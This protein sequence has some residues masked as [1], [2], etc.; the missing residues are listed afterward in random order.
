MITD[1]GGPGAGT[2]RSREP[3]W[4]SPRDT[5]ATE[6]DG[7]AVCGIR[8]RNSAF[9]KIAVEPLPVGPLFHRG[10]RVV[11]SRYKATTR[12]QS[13]LLA[14]SSNHREVWVEPKGLGF[15]SCVLTIAGGMKFTLFVRMDHLVDWSYQE[16]VVLSRTIPANRSIS[17]KASVDRAKPA[18]C[19]HFKTGHFQAAG[20]RPIEFYRTLSPE[21]KS[22]WTFVRQLRGPHFSTCA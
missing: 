13:C 8:A 6:R 22:M 9:K 1:C 18:I 20:S 5:L 11:L 16:G 17:A 4:C 2:S 7:S 14:R 10:A 12:S 19:R 15:L 3:P 21:C